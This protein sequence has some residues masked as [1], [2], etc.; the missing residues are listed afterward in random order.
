LPGRLTALTAAVPAVERRHQAVIAQG[1]LAEAARELAYQAFVA[2]GLTPTAE[3]LPPAVSV[4]GGW[5]FRARRWKREVGDLWTLAARG[6]VRRISPNALRRLD[7]TLHNL[8]AAV[9]AG[10]VR[11]A[12][13]DSAI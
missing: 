11:L 7:L 2:L 8:L 3:A 4:S 12:A 5:S 13:T 1:N 6:P 9:A 10:E